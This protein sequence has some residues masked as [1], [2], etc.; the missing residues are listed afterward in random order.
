MSKK[1]LPKVAVLLATYNGGLYLKDQLDSIFKQDGIDFDLFISDDNSSDQTLS[2][3]NDYQKKY[4]N[5]FLIKQLRP[6]GAAQNFYNL[7]EQVNV[8][9][10]DYF[11]L[12]DQDDV[13]PPHKISR[14]IYCLNNNRADGYSSDFLF[15]HDKSSINYYKKSFGQ[16][17]YDYLFETP[18]PGCT[19]TLSSSLFGALKKFIRQNKIHFFYHDWL[20]YAFARTNQFIW[21]IDDS[22]NLFYRQHHSNVAGVN[23]GF[24]AQ[25][26]RLQRILF[27]AWYNE[28]YSLTQLVGPKNLVTKDK[29]QLFYFF[30]INWRHTRRNI[31]HAFLMLPF[32]ILIG[33]QRA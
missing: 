29:S 11:S 15:F 27:G 2:I 22:P 1:K 25:L 10:Y 5:I 26:I 31:F 4:K 23:Y 18:G 21:F 17:K 24:K 12:A 3:I 28:I 8:N 14:S 9:K 13:W 30:V 32:L 20:I 33:M 6:Q 7:I 16:K 19:F